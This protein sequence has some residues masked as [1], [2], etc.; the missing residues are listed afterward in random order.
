MK[1]YFLRTFVSRALL[2]LAIVVP[3]ASIAAPQE[4][5]TPEAAVDAL[6]A[7]LKADGDAALVT[8]FGEEHKNLIIDSDRAAALENRNKILAAMQARRVL[9]D[10]SPDRRILL[11]GDQAWPLPIP[12]RAFLPTARRG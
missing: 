4:F 1:S 10:P 6:A 5:A 9:R 2:M 3:M 12:T 8:L 7:A 11:I